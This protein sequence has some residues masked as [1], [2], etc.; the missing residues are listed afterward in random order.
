MILEPQVVVILYAM[1][2]ELKSAGV[3]SLNTHYAAHTHT[4]FPSWLS[5]YR[6]RVP[7]NVSNF[8]VWLKKAPTKAPF[9]ER[10]EN[11]LEKGSEAG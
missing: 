7:Y 4:R 11:T 1:N 10:I 9:A 3:L 5:R 2:S 6:L 8:F